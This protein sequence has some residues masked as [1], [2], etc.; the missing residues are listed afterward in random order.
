MNKTN[1]PDKKTPIKIILIG[2]GKMGGALLQGWHDSDLNIEV[3]VIDPHVT[4]S[5]VIDHAKTPAEAAENLAGADV[6]ILAVK[7]QVMAHICADLKSYTPEKA[8]IISIA[9]GQSIANYESY[10]G[11]AQ[12]IIRTMPN[13]PAA[14]GKGI[15]VGVANA[16]VSAQQKSTAAA[17]LECSGVFEWVEDESLLNAVTA[18]SGSGPAYVFHLIEMLTAAGESIGLA[19]ALAETLARQTVIGSAALAEADSHLSATTLR[20]NVTSPGGTTAAALE[21]LMN[22][23]LEKIYKTA[24]AAAKKRGEELNS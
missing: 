9:A 5:S 13:I 2:Y 7:P 17:I 3:T 6:I 20:E 24:L 21:V 23:E 14:I 18:L 19:P 1:T 16:H 12:P 10:F 8:L 11:A 22:G 15:T 4:P